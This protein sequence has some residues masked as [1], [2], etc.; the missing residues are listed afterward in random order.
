M[1]SIFGQLDTSGKT[2]EKNIRKLTRVGLTS[3]CVTIPM[4]YINDLKWRRGQKV[5]V[6][7][8]GKKLVVEDW[9]NDRRQ[10]R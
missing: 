7:K 4:E 5:V 2:S 1:K 6:N 10:I 8:Q 3:L 9:K